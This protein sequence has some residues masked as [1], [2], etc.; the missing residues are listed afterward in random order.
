MA[1]QLNENIQYI[2]SAT[3]ELLNNGLVYIGENNLDAELNPITIYA[4]VGL[5][6]TLLNPQRIGPD[7]RVSNKIF[8]PGKYSL[9]VKDADNNQKLND[10]SLGEAETI[11]NTPLINVQGINAITADAS[12]SIVSLVDGQTYILT[13]VAAN[14]GAMTLEIDSLPAYPI[15]KYHDI[16]MESGDFEDHQIMA[17]IWNATDSVFELT[18][19]TAALDASEISNTPA[20]NIAATDVQAAINELDTEKAGLVGDNAYTGTAQY[21]AGEGIV[22]NG[23]AITAANTLDDYEE[24]VW[25]PNIYGSTT[26]GTYTEIINYAEYTKIGRQYTCIA[27]IE[28]SAASGGAGTLYINGLP[29]AYAAGGMASGS[30]AVKSLNLVNANPANVTLRRQTTASSTILIITESVD[31]ATWDN[32]LITGVSTSTRLTL[33]FSFIV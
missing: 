18:S 19:N 26:A 9:K 17:V 6:T 12:P 32:T 29:E 15:K 1:S 16:D 14:T 20:G 30:I 33:A 25:T 3:G 23:D 5:T 28:F 8:I 7:G 31:N 4:D 10:L 22:F 27:D 2:D 21:A 11:S 13:T 24:G